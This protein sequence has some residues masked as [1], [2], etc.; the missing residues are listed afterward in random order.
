[1]SSEG[2]AVNDRGQAAGTSGRAFLYTGAPGSGVMHELGTLGGTDSFGY[3]INDAG[4]VAGDSRT[5]PTGHRRAFRYDGTPGSG[6]VMRD[7]GTLGGAESFGYAINE[8][9]QV[10]G[11]SDIQS[12]LQTHAFRYDGTP[13]G[14]G[15]MHD[16]G[17]LGGSNSFAQAINDAGQ[18]A[19]S[20][21]P[22]AP[23][24]IFF[25][26]FRYDGTPGSG[27]V[28]LD[29]G[30]LGGVE[31]FGNA[32]NNAG[33]VAGE[34]LITGNSER[35]AFR[36][37]GT[38][39]SGGVMHDLGTLGGGV[40]VGQA[41]DNRGQVVGFS[42]TVGAEQHA[43]LYTGTPG[44]DGQMI[45]LDV[46]LDITNPAEGGKWTLSVAHG[47]SNTGWITGRGMYD[48]DGAGGIA[49]NDRAYLL[50]ASSLVPEP[51][52]LALLA[53]SIPALLRRCHQSRQDV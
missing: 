1:M 26:A 50:D 2:R 6:G 41:I 17:T 13:G 37:D 36:Y 19:G 30:T 34:S 28:M 48:P 25:H 8:A 21:H 38:P 52:G 12:N 46:W 18:I 42:Y 53:A 39:G 23:A 49:A 3:A 14:G 40:S 9:G 4:Q 20:S 27:G 7:L 11:R 22:P 47:I 16:L 44:G 35:H 43:F 15:V 31:S 32:I 10:A 45:D 5:F 24:D 29:L 51:S 33:Q